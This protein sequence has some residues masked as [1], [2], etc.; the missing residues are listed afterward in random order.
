MFIYHP[1][2]IFTVKHETSNKLPFLKNYV[3]HST[4]GY[5]TTLFYKP[6]FTGVYLNWTSLNARRYK[7]GLIKRLLDRTTR[8]RSTDVQLD[9][10]LIKLKNISKNNYPK[11]VIDREFKKFWA[12]K[13]NIELEPET[14]TTLN[15][16]P[17]V[18]K[19]ILRMK[20]RSKLSKLNLIKITHI[21]NRS[22]FGLID[23][24]GHTTNA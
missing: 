22:F 6:T 7:I 3:K 21:Q 19:H 1:N 24:H 10:E 11:G 13:G 20:T 4:N 16:I 23:T 15:S 2:I 5:N 17:Q 9:L 8:I 14:R 12:R 18:E